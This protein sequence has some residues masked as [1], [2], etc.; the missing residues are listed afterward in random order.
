MFGVGDSALRLRAYLAAL[1][2]QARAQLREDLDH[3]AGR[4]A[5]FE[6]QAA[7]AELRRLDKDAAAAALFF[8]P[9]EL[10]L[11]D[12]D[13][14]HVYPGCVARAA[15]PALWAGISHDLVPGD[16]AAFTRAAAEAFEAKAAASAHA[17]AG[18]FQ[19][20]VVA[21]LRTIF[22]GDDAAACH[23]FQ[24]RIGTPR[25]EDEAATLRWALRGRDSHAALG[26]HFPDARADLSPDH[27]PACI[28]LIEEAARPREII[29]SALI[30]VMRRLAEPWQIVR[31]ATYASRSNSAARIG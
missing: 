9:L 15:L 29:L 16:A 30:V 13:M 31:L 1:T 28:A 12:A 14:A 10:F 8:Q 27:V 6:S 11:I 22:G 18:D 21:A 26:R 4:S 20:R 23:A 19:D 25:A 2:P 17:L 5:P 24:R 7:L 3:G